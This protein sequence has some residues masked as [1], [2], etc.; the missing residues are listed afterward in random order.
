[1]DSEYTCRLGKTTIL[2]SSKRRLC[3]MVLPMLALIG[4]KSAIVTAP[5]ASSIKQSSESVQN[6]AE[7]NQAVL[8]EAVLNQAAQRQVVAAFYER[9]AALD[10]HGLPTEEQSAQLAPF[11][12]SKLVRLME[13]ARKQQALDTARH[14]GSEPPLLQGSPFVSLFEGVTNMLAIEPALTPSVWTVYL[15]WGQGS[16]QVQWTDLAV[17][18]WESNRWVVSDIIFNGQW[19][20]A[21]RGRLSEVL[22]SVQG[23]KR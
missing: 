4:C 13:Y 22:G 8:N 17:M 12:T 9:V 18:A 1:M 6:Q 15:A 7:Q 11:V 20:F 19:D 23:I 5:D 16:E 21:R 14:R 2:V 3:L 10:V